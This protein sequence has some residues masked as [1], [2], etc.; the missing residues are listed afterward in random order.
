M[1]LFF[2]IKFDF[3]TNSVAN[4]KFSESILHNNPIGRIFETVLRFKKNRLKTKKAR[5]ASL[6]RFKKCPTRE[7]TRRGN[8]EIIMAQNI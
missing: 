1:R 4:P 6:L 5:N 2:W 8:H 3:V 7:P